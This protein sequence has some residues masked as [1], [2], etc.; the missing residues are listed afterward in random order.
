MIYSKRAVRP[1]R[2]TFSPPS[3]KMQLSQTMKFPPPNLAALKSKEHSVPV[4]N[5][6]DLLLGVSTSPQRAKIVR[7]ETFGDQ[8]TQMSTMGALST[9]HAKP[10]P[11][12]HMDNHSSNKS[13]TIR[14]PVSGFEHEEKRLFS[15][16][17]E[18]RSDNKRELLGAHMARPHR[19]RRQLVELSSIKGPHSMKHPSWPDADT[20]FVCCFVPCSCRPGTEEPVF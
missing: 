18:M 1:C 13:L 4:K 14:L 2:Q 7:L 17:G 5:Q 20:A 15:A 9:T 19:D 11:E 16:V 3:K 10:S 8:N 6:K 12:K